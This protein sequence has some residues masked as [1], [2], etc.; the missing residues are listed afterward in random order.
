[1]QTALEVR[2]LRKRFSVGV[3]SCAASADVLRGVDLSVRTGQSVAIVGASG[4]GKSTLLLC[5]AGLLTPDGGEIRWF[6]DAARAAAARRVVY[7]VTRTDLL[8]T[9]RIDQRNVHLLDVDHALDHAA[10]LERW[11]AARLVLGDAVLFV[12]RDEALA[13]HVAVRTLRLRGGVL[14]S[15]TPP[16]AR[17]AEAAS[18]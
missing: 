6:G 10:Q 14:Q 16:R 11:I 15:V 5:L 7:H 4:A 18:G 8:R 13:R 2:S 9:G 17:V 3:G 12:T 1:M